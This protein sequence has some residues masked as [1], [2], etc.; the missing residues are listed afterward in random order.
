VKCSGA[1]STTA[2]CPARAPAALLCVT[3]DAPAE[4]ARAAA[5]SAGDRYP[6]TPAVAAGVARTAAQPAALASVAA[7]AHHSTVSGWSPRRGGVSAGAR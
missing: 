7:S 6:I 1:P 2:S 4:A 3:A 5:T